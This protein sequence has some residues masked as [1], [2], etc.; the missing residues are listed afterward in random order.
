M[1]TKSFVTGLALAA[2][3]A[4]PLAAQLAQVDAGIAAYKKTSGI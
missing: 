3:T 1:K 4:A 2:V